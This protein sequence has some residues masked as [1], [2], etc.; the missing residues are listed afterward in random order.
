MNRDWEPI[1]EKEAKSLVIKKEGSGFTVWIKGDN[2]HTHWLVDASVLKEEGVIN[3]GHDI[4][5]YN[6]KAVFN[7]NRIEI[8][9]RKKPVKS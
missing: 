8:V 3:L 6:Y 7:K 5:N 4:P 1:T 9:K 2:G